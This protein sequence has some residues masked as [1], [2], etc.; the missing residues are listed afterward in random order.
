[1][2]NFCD[3]DCLCFTESHLDN[4]VDNANFLLTNAFAIPYRKDR[5]YHVGGI[6]DYIDNN[7]LHKRKSDLEIFREESV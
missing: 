4:S 7:L 2:D 5:T 6:L 3:Y 1:M